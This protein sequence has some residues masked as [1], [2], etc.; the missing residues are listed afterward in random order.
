MKSW[1]YLSWTLVLSFSCAA[2]V[3]CGQTGTTSLVQANAEANP[4]DATNRTGPVTTDAELFAALDL[5]LPALKPVRDA[6]AAHPGDYGPAK[7]ALGKYLRERTSTT[8]WFDP[9]KVDRKIDFNQGSADA[10]ASGRVK[11]V[12]IT[13]DFPN[14]DI[15]WFYNH[16]TARQDLPD[17]NEWVW[18]LNRMDPWKPLGRAYWGAGDEKYAKAWVKQM[19]SWV[20]SAPRPDTVKNEPNSVWRTIETGIRMSGSWPDAYHRFLLS[21]AFTDEDKI[22]YLKSSMEQA[23][24]LSQNPST[25]NWLTMEMSGLYSVASVFPELKAAAAWRK[26]AIKTLHGELNKQF[27]PDGAHYEASPGYHQVALE[28]IL[29]IPKLAQKT[30]R[31]SELPSD[32]T[33]RMEKAYDF[34][35]Y[36]MTPNRD[37]PRFN[38][39]WPIDVPQTMKDAVELFPQRQDFAWIASGGKT[40]AAPK[41]TSYQFPYVGY[42]AMRSGWNTDANYLGFDSGPL[43]FWHVHQDKLNVVVW[44]Y[45]REL[46]FD[47]GGGSY[48][49]SKWRSYATDTFSHN[50][51]LVDGKPQRRQTK[52]RDANVSKAP[53]DVSWQSQPKF[54]YAVASYSDGYGKENDRIATHT[55]RVLFVKPN[56]FVIADT[57]APSDAKEHTY[58]ARWHLLT[59]QSQR[60]EASGTVVTT[61]AQMPNLAVVPVQ[62]DGLDVKVA[63]AQTNKEL[64]GWNVRKDMAPQYLP[65]TTVLHTRRGAGEQQFLTLLVPIKSG[66]TNPVQAARVTPAPDQ[67][68][69]TLDI[70]YRGGKRVT[71]E[72]EP[73]PQG[74]LRLK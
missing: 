22:L 12:A 25:G 54:D 56:L 69:S 28:N 43:G 74:S 27:L 39:S 33:S 15:D 63:S 16:T 47:S 34:N 58:Q 72:I 6:V 68:S 64:L 35:L 66:E 24:Y 36:L 52:S 7:A 71:V 55:R 50:T 21:P 40:G 20:V 53:I 38:D 67:K 26:Q 10:A 61:D 57:L 42:S 32:F 14:G 45:G 18:Q 70:T 31:I 4:A 17:N 41:T 13:H 8:W 11:V 23:Q 29:F 65:A 62:T 46:L 3:S 48:E 51:V 60:D 9:Q 19:R 30:K 44:A 49:E 37:L 59:T 5:S 73:G 2:M 1:T